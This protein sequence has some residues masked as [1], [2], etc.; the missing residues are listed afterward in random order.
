VIHR[1]P[2]RRIP[3]VVVGLVVVAV[4][5]GFVVLLAKLSSDA[6]RRAAAV[7]ATTPA[8]AA[9]T[10]STT[11]TTATAATSSAASPL[12]TPDGARLEVWPRRLSG[13]T[14]VLATTSTVAQAQAVAQQVASDGIQVGILSS[15]E[16]PPLKPGVWIVF[17]GHYPAQ[18]QA[19]QVVAALQAVGQQQAVAGLIGRSGG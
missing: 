18:A 7:A 10:T 6:N 14:V 17:T 8:P 2:D 16:H 9:P 5:A 3:I 1:P 4:L 13:W 12:T 11:A 19:D 15:S